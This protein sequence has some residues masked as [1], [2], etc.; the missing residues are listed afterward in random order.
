MSKPLKLK[1]G[2]KITIPESII[3]ASNLNVKR[4]IFFYI[5]ISGGYFFSNKKYKNLACYGEIKLDSNYSFIASENIVKLFGNLGEKFYF[6]Y[7]T[8]KGILHITL[9]HVDSRFLFYNLQPIDYKVQI[10]SELVSTK[11]VNFDKP[12]YMYCYR[13]S[14]TYRGRRGCF[15][16]SNESFYLN[17]HM[18]LGKITLDLENYFTFLATTDNFTDIRDNSI[19]ISTDNTDKHFIYKLLG[20]KRIIL[21][22]N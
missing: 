13:Y 4:P 21:Q 11:A 19:C 3:L 22:N 10:P 20:H 9:A 17:P 5:S 8:K 15:Y 7:Y 1:A 12:V 14:N 2:M 16:L 6:F 18:C